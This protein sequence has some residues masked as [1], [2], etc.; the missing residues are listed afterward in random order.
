MPPLQLISVALLLI[1]LE[2]IKVLL[3]SILFQCFQRSIG[4][5]F[6]Q[7]HWHLPFSMT[8]F[9]T[10]PK[11]FALTALVWHSHFLWLHEQFAVK[12]YLPFWKL[13]VLWAYLLSL[14]ILL[15]ECCSV[16]NYE[17][18]PC[19]DPCY[20]WMLSWGSQAEEVWTMFGWLS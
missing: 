2:L 14:S 16:W 6:Y 11:L 18:F 1:L 3:Y 7:W 12:F 17:C 13:M 10:W 4:K 8:K 5:R 19:V 20:P 15:F 9:F